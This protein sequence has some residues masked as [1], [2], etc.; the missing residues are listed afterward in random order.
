VEGG[1]LRT[2][3]DDSDEESRSWGGG[4]GRA[5]ARTSSGDGR[6]MLWTTIES[7]DG[8]NLV[9]RHVGVAN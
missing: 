1:V 3:R 6:G 9:G 5:K 8:A 4:I 2:G 7:R